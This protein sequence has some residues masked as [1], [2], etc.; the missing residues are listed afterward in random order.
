MTQ[1]DYLVPLVAI[2]IGLALTDLAASFH[3]L[4]R[5]RPRVRWHWFPFAAAVM[6]ILAIL[7]MW[8]NLPHLSRPGQGFTVGMFLPFL[9]ELM[10]LYLLA[11]AALPDD[12]PAG[13]V[14]LQAYYFENRRY[15]WSLFAA[16]L[17]MFVLHR[18]GTAWAVY[19]PRAV[20]RMIPNVV[21][22]VILIA[23]VVS[24]AISGRRWWHGLWLL[25]LPLFYLF[26]V[27]SRE[28]SAGAG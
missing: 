19:G 5:G 8:W 22:N 24:L 12:V 13:G 20:A 2:M 28:L 10:L 1:F 21:P 3:R 4:M 23:I 26:T 25:L 6:V 27:F 9:A 14:D 16:L 7:E 15:F 17:A 11:S 18:L